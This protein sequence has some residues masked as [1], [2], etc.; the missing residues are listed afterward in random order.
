MTISAQSVS[1]GRCG[2][3]GGGLRAGMIAG[4][5]VLVGTMYAALPPAEMPAAGKSYTIADLKLDLRWVEAGTFLM[6]S[7]ADEEGRDRAE[8]PQTRVTLSRGFWLGRTE[9]TQA[10][11]LALTGA[12]P[13]RFTTA[14]PDA[15]V[16]RVSWLEAMQLCAKLNDRERAAGRLPD[17]YV[18]TL[19]TEAQWEYAC[20]AG[21]TGATAGNLPAMSWYDG[22][23]GETAHPVAQRAPNGWGF[24]D[25]SGNVLEWCYDWFGDYPGGSVTDPTGPKSGYFR[26]AR[27][28]SWRTRLDVGR[29]AARAGG[30]EGRQDYTIGLRL[31]LAPVR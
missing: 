25:L 23:S 9:L 12:N 5:A 18:Y 13:S 14:G 31:A 26:I 4:F 2:S 17:G 22:N 8:G 11:Y 1:L 15:P 7:P 16:E 29:S 20:R 19:P 6:G 27:G 21:T 10:Q 28:G 30:S 24:S 3:S